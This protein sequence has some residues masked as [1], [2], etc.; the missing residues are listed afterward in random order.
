VSGGGQARR[1]AE[2]ARARETRRWAQ[3]EAGAGSGSRGEER[4]G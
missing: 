4:K 3:H 1:G 2:H